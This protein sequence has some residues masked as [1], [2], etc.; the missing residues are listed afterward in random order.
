MPDNREWWQKGER[1]PVPTSDQSAQIASGLGQMMTVIAEA[2]QP[3]YDAAD[4]IRNQLLERGYSPTAAEQAAM[5]HILLAQQA[6]WAG[7]AG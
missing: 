7:S 3:V 2:M 5:Q 1:P 6:M 4:G